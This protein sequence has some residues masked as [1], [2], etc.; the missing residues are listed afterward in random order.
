M[1]LSWS[2]VASNG[3]TD[4][5]AKEMNESEIR[6]SAKMKCFIIVIFFVIICKDTYFNS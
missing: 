5:C 4:V 2:L 6:L 3:I 1:P